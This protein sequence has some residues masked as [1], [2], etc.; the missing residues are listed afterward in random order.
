MLSAGLRPTHFQ[1]AESARIRS[2]R[3][4]ARLL[5]FRGCVG[6]SA[7]STDTTIR[8]R[9]ADRLRTFGTVLHASNGCTFI[10][11][12]G[13][14]DEEFQFGVTMPFRG[15]TLDADTFRTRVNNFFDHDVIGESNTSLSLTIQEALIRGWELTLRSPRLRTRPNSSRIFQSGCLW[16]GRAITGGLTDG[17]TNLCDPNP[18]LCPLDHDQRNTLNVGADVSLPWRSMPRPTFTM[19]RASA[20]HFPASLI[21]ATILPG[22]TTFDLSV[23]KDFGERYSASLNAVNVANRRVELDNSTTLGVSTGIIRARSLSR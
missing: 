11:L 12:H 20:T 5:P 4:L 10:P 16:R 6:P 19:V 8:R 7:D 23:G 15:W 17:T 18:G 2:A 13:E 22:H 3:V 9:P 14:R 21:R 1:A